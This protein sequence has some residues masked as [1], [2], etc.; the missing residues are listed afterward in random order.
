MSSRSPPWKLTNCSAAETENGSS[1]S[2][3]IT[4]RRN[5]EKVFVITGTSFVAY[6]I[7]ASGRKLQILACLFSKMEQIEIYS[8]HFA[9]ATP[10]EIGHFYN[11]KYGEIMIR[12]W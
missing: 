5:R 12:S 9:H 11:I 7:K 3:N 2:K 1:A 8:A 10:D 6:K 4:K